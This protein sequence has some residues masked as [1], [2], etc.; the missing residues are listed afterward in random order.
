MS[1]PERPDYDMMRCPLCDRWF[2]PL[3]YLRHRAALED[4]DGEITY[5]PVRERLP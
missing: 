5:R 2:T 4:A 1:E 3:D